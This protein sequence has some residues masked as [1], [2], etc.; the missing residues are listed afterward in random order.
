MQL[1]SLECEI[2]SN[3]DPTPEVSQIIDLI[4]KQAKLDGSTFARNVTPANRHIYR[5]NQGV[6]PILRGVTIGSDFTLTPTKRDEPEIQPNSPLDE[7]RREPVAGIADC[8][9]LLG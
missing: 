4:R 1:H 6:V 3:N 2:A 9:H 8:A 7:F 5:R